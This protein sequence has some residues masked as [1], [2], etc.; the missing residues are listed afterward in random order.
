MAGATGPLGNEVL[1]RL[2]G[3]HA[4]EAV[5][6]LA[7]EPITQGMRAVSALLVG[8]QAIGQWPLAAADAGV[9]MFD[10]P[11][12]YYDRERALWTPQP[13][14]LLELS[15]WM[16][17]SGV[18]TL[19]V[20]LPHAQGQL[21]DALKRGLAS[22]DE[23]A[24]ATLGFE[25]VLFVRTPEKASN[26][27]GAGYLERTAAWMLSILNF[28]V[29]GSEQPPRASKVAEFVAEALRML[30]PGVHVAAPELVWQ[31]AHGDVRKVVSSWL[32]GGVGQSTAKSSR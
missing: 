16:R 18:H 14:Q 27:S 19:V 3:A 22:L 12:L 11:R 2:A 28:M 31:G 17:R 20:V 24:V 10:P 9:V 29:S 1:R 5:Q 26:R 32:S 21:P 30:P 4:W 13:V 15:Q 6:I 25:R 8:D 23:H 7:R